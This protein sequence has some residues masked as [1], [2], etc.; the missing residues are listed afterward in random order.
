MSRPT[1]PQILVPEELEMQG[2]LGSIAVP[3]SQKL[4]KCLHG[5][6]KQNSGT[7]HGKQVTDSQILVPR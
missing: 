1:F 5:C 7:K 2:E 6:R 4:I 3:P